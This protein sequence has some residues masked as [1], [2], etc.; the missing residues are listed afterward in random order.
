MNYSDDIERPRKGTHFVSR[1]PRLARSD[2]RPEGRG[3][4]RPC[5]DHLPAPRQRQQTAARRTKEFPRAAGH[6]VRPGT[7][8]GRGGGRL[9]GRGGRD[10][11][12]GHCHPRRAK[13]TRNEDTTQRMGDRGVKRAGNHCTIM[14]KDP[15]RRARQ[16][17]LRMEERNQDI[18]AATNR[19]RR[20][21][22]A[23]DAWM[24]CST[25]RSAARLGSDKP[26]SNM[27]RN[28]AKWAR[29]RSLWSLRTATLV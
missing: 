21:H 15:L 14:P 13:A 12:N 7:Q 3:S 27:L 10:G 8:R 17:K 6:S 1:P 24:P 18:H 5:L 25:G 29:E 26:R 2:A 22:K 19:Q 28:A 9:D 16:R 23:R 20:R 11:D 4:G